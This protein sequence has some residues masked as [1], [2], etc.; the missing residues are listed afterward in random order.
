MLF[1]SMTPGAVSEVI[2]TRTVYANNAGLRHLSG[3]I[4]S[5]YIH[6]VTV[7]DI[8]YI[9]PVYDI[10]SYYCIVYDSILHY[11]ICMMSYMKSGVYLP[12]LAE[13]CLSALKLWRMPCAANVYGSGP[14]LVP[15]GCVAVG[16]VDRM[17]YIGEHHMGL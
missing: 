12:A 4:G 15:L 10:T 13:L 11:S 7:Y 9:I 16:K 17:R 1:D 8:S 6:H 5:Y 2:K 14:Q 3:P